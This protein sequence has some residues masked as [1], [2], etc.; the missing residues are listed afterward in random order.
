[1]EE[2]KTVVEWAVKVLNTA[3]TDLKAAYTLRAL[4]L[5]HSVRNAV[6][7][8]F[9]KKISSRP[10]A[11]RRPELLLL[12]MLSAA[13]FHRGHCR[14]TTLARVWRRTDQHG[15]STLSCSRRTWHPS[16]ARAAAWPTESPWSIPWFTLSPWYDNPF[17][18]ITLGKQCIHTLC[19]LD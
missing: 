11:L 17:I 5:W 18:F 9:L 13:G 3:D 1:M 12:T 15:R 16:G 6:F 19:S 7:V 8:F 10:C 4:D 14:R 2:P